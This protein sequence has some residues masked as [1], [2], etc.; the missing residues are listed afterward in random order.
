MEEHIDLFQKIIT[1]I[2]DK[3]DY[4]D[5]ISLKG[6]SNSILMKDNKFQ[7]IDSG[8]TTGARIRVLKNGA[9]GFAYTNDISK[10]EEITE[11]AIKI[12]NSL[13]GEVELAEADIIEDKVKANSKIKASDIDI[14]EKKELIEDANKASNVGSVVST[15]AS[16]LDVESED[17]FINTEG[18]QILNESSRIM[19]SL[20]AVA[21]NGE[22]MQF[23]HDSLGGTKGYEILK[24]ADIETF[25]RKI[26]EKATDLLDATP[27]PSGRFDIIA[28][29]LLTGVFIHE[30]VGHATEADLMLIDDS[31]LKDKMNTK[32]GSDIVNIFDDASNKDAFGYYPYDVEGVKTSKNQL[33]KNGELVSML[34]SRETAAKF[35]R[36]SSG[37]ARSAISDQPIVRMSNTYL[38]PGDMSFEELLED[39]KDGIYLKGSRGG[40][41]D[42]GKGNFQFNATEA[43]KIEN[44]ELKDHYRDVSLSG[45]ILETLMGVDA[46]GSDFKLSVGFCGKDGQ[47]A[48]VGDGGPH[49]KILNAMVGGSS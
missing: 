8:I 49:T 5:I 28:D 39:V 41:V 15:T 44:G 2:Q 4:A 32:I 3:V 6:N 37:N 47:T 34:S 23:S 45:N 30:A 12:S 31:V 20:N 13:S 9:W 11:N 7:N 26:G 27:A 25:G 46:I 1:K 21:S 18:S 16:Y 29:N 42:T 33:V 48:P 38:A 35:G 24:N 43:Y 36:R 14:D 19:L 40:Q 10:L 22:I 17:F